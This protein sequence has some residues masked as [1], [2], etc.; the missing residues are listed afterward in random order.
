MRE[1]ERSKQRNHFEESRDL[2]LIEQFTSYDHM[3]EELMIEELI[4][5]TGQTRKQ[6]KFCSGNFKRGELGK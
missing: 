3:I 5:L 6:K 4:S 1:T 2:G